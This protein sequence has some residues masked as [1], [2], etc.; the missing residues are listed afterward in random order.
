MEL[1][2]IRD[3]NILIEISIFSLLIFIFTFFFLKTASQKVLYSSFSLFFYLYNGYG[4]S[5]VKGVHP[6]FQN[7]YYI[8]YIAFSISYL[9]AIKVISK[10]F[11]T[12]NFTIGKNL[13]RIASSKSHAFYAIFLFLVFSIIPLLFPENK[14]HLLLN[15]PLPDVSTQFFEFYKSEVNYVTKLA[16]YMTYIV[17][18]FYLL[19][20]YAFRKSPLILAIILFLPLYFHYVEISYINRAYVLERLII[21]FFLVFKYSPGLRKIVILGAII[22][23]PLL[24]V[25]LAQYAQIRS[26]AKAANITSTEAVS[27]I[28]NSELTFP[29]FSKKIINSEKRINLK[30]YF[31]WMVTL[32]IPKLIIGKVPNASA[33]AEMS[34][35][36]LGVKQGRYGYFALLAGLLTESVYTFGTNWFFL[37]AVFLACIMAIIAKFME[38][39]IVLYPLLLFFSIVFS[40]T[41]NRGGIGSALAII[42]NQ[43]LFFYIY[44]FIIYFRARNKKRRFEIN[45]HNQENISLLKT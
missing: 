12:F 22:V 28:L 24:V 4:I 8:F 38:S 6:D 30:N 44:N 40:Y 16:D 35:I 14:L 39:S 13:E 21:Y 10:P 17:F 23:L 1:I 31:I 33:G 3:F 9:I 20:L 45:I 11:K 29:I 32:P 41:L 34:E 25:K 43:F 36:L 2:E 42:V 7:I 15:P 27:Y 19:S 26:G 18:P 5:F 37:H